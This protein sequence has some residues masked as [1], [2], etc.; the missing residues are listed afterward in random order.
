MQHGFHNRGKKAIEAGNS[1]NSV[2]VNLTGGS[3][4]AK[5]AIDELG[6]STW[7]LDGSFIGIE[8]T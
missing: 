2:L 5:G 4:T 3:S 6:V 7:H 1:L 8:A